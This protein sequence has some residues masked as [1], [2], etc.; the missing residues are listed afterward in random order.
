MI[1]Q[2]NITLEDGKV[3]VKTYSDQNFLIHKIG[4]EE[5]YGE[6]LDIVD[7]GYVYEETDIKDE[8]S[9]ENIEEE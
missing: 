8:E 7:S 9:S 2:E 3:F 1:V 6:A 5:Y 4:T